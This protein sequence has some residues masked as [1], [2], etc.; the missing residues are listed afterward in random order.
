MK[1]SIAARAIQD[2]SIA[3]NLCHLSH[4][5]EVIKDKRALSRFYVIRYTSY[6]EN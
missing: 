2:E 3:S 1:G 4:I 6:N 5:C